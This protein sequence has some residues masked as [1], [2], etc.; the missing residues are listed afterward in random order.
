MKKIYVPLLTLVLFISV[1]SAQVVTSFTV[2]PLYPTTTDT[3]TV[4]VQCDFTNAPCEGF[5][6]VDNISGTQ[7]NATAFHCVGS[8]STL[9]TDFDTLVI[10]P[11][12]AGQY[13]LS[14]LL[15]QGDMM[16]GCIVGAT[17]PGFG[18]VL[19][20]V[21]QATSIA[22]I[23]H[24]NELAISPNP[25]DGNFSI[26]RKSIGESTIKI[27]STDGRLMQS[28]LLSGTETNV[29]CSLKPGVYIVAEESAGETIFGRLMIAR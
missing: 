24:N 2:D 14:V 8:L 17:P 27:F 10:A 20:D 28:L 23:T 11:L 5:A 3:I 12:A 19:I 6:Q 25:S 1:A 15:L 29:A 22:E 4:Y 13:T 9:C 16:A 18:A 7:I 26:K 21:T